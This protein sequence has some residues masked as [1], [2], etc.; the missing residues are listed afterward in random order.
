MFVDALKSASQL[1]RIISRSEMV[2]LGGTKGRPRI[3]IAVSKKLIALTAGG[4]TASRKSPRD[5]TSRTAI[6]TA[7]MCESNSVWR[8]DGFMFRA[9]AFWQVIS[10]RP[11]AKRRRAVHE[12][13]A[14]LWWP[15]SAVTGRLKF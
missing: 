7:E 4:H 9:E 3:A 12:C 6:V 14:I 2:N 1:T 11:A 13:V 15:I 5:Q 10:I 8:R